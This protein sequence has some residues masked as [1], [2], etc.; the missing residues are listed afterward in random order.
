[1]I[2]PSMESY[3]PSIGPE[4]LNFNVGFDQSNTGSP[5]ASKAGAKYLSNRSQRFSNGL[6][7][8]F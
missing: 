4:I 7:E 2:L 8:I 6:T 3:A 5:L 1:M